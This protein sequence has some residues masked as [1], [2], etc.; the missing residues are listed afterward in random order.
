M[1]VAFDGEALV[2]AVSDPD[3][4]EAVKVVRQLARREVR[5]VLSAPGAI[6]RAQERMYGPRP[7][8]RFAP[9]APARAKAPPPPASRA[10]LRR[11]EQLARHAGLDFVELEPRSDGTDPVDL[12]AAAR[13]PPRVCR[14]YRLLPVAAEIGRLVVAVDDPFDADRG[15]IVF[16]LTAQYPRLV[17]VAARELD[18]AIARVFG[19]IDG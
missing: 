11:A 3:D 14:S 16:A 1:P 4:A 12:D 2:V 6:G 8:P 18:R 19:T 5:V 13:I 9:R 10:E 17:V 15:R 7:E